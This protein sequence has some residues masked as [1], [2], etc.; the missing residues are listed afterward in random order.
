MTQPEKVAGTPVGATGTAPT[1]PP[2]R[3]GSGV[4]RW[5]RDDASEPLRRN[6]GLV[7]VLVV[8]YAIGAWSR[9]DIFLHV[10]RLWS[11]ELTVL[12]LASSIG[13][14]AIGMTFIIISGGI[15]L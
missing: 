2:T 9:P 1:T 3:S 5:F 13:V 8:L 4:G 7:A 6:L 15:D 14:V 10:H 12:T 11:N